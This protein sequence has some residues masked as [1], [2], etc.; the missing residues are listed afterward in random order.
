[1]GYA[2]LRP[3]LG[4]FCEENPKNPGIWNM[5]FGIPEKSHP[6]KKFRSRRL[7]LQLDFKEI[8][9]DLNP[10]H[11]II[12]LIPKK[13]IISS[14]KNLIPRK[15]SR[16]QIDQMINYLNVDLSIA[17]VQVGWPK[18]RNRSRSTNFFF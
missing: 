10:K 18:F 11:S 6:M 1:M 7:S 16:D 4:F 15:K 9:W 14:R 12:F 8:V 5:G 3:R 13:L 2:S 17:Y